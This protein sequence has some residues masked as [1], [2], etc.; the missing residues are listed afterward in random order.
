MADDAAPAATLARAE[1][2]RDWRPIADYAVIGD[3]HGAA[4]VASDGGV[5]WCA[6]GRFDAEPLLCRL[7]DRARGGFLATPVEAV[8]TSRRAYL[9]DTNVLA[10][11]VETDTGTLRRTDFMPVGRAVDSGLFDYVDL[12]AP[13][14]LV[15]TIEC[16]RGTVVFDLLVA[17]TLGFGRAAARLRPAA[18]GATLDGSDVQIASSSALAIGEGGAHARV[19]LR[20]GES[21]FVVVG[22]NA[23]RATPAAVGRL[24]GVTLAF[25]REWS[26]FSRYEGPYRAAVMRSALALKLMTYAPTGAAVAAVTTSLPEAIGGERN[27]DYRFCWV[28]DASLMLHA[29]ALLGYSGEARRF[30]DFIVHTCGQTPVQTQVMYGIDMTCELPEYT[31]DHLSGWRD[32]RPVRIGNAAYT[33]RQTDLFGYILDAACVFDALGGTLGDDDRRRHGEIVDFIAHCWLEPD[34]G[35]WEIRGAPRHFVLSKAMCWVVVDRAIRLHGERDDWVALRSAIWQAIDERG[36]APGRRQLVDALDTPDADA[37][38]VVLLQLPLLGLPLDESTRRETTA[39]V[40]R[41]LRRG[42]F[43]NRYRTDSACAG[44]GLAGGEGAFLVGS[45]WL[46]DAMLVDGRLAEAEVLFESLLAQASDLGLYSEQVDPASGELLG[47]FPQAF[48]HL[49]LIVS[50][51][52]IALCREHGAEAMRGGPAERAQRIVGATL[53]WRG[54]LAGIGQTGR[55]SLSSSRESILDLNRLLRRE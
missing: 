38:D 24:G 12:A 37:V 53:G 23:S 13:G 49:G 25:W 41:V 16:S 51:S 39:A 21:W 19:E 6:L 55:I 42:D 4:L 2:D 10:T 8:Q 36:R 44:D 48:T 35:L 33:Q 40:E 27:W 5:D 50:A 17:P 3:C 22:A 7:L 52:Y 43:V 32:S 46:V 11:D 54:V 31:V 45:F 9:G 30:N 29:L 47:N 15:R 28:R 14:W 20:A 26:A 1:R 34:L 18:F